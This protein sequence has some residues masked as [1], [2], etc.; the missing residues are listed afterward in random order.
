MTGAR[1]ER[2]DLEGEQQRL[3]LEIVETYKQGTRERGE[4]WFSKTNSGS[5]LQHMGSDRTWHEVPDHDLAALRRSGLLDMRRGGGRYPPLIHT[6]SPFGLR[7][8]DWVRSQDAEPVGQVEEAVRE[9]VDS[10]WFV[11]RYP[12]SHA[13]WSSAVAM[14]WSPDVDRNLSQIGHSCREAM[15]DFAEELAT[16]A[17]ML[18]DVD[19]DKQ[20]TVSR[21]RDVLAEKGPP[22]SRAAFNGAL[23]AYW[24][25]LSDQVMRQEHA[26]QKEG[27][28]IGWEDA[29]RVVLHTLVV[30][31]EVARVAE[32]GQ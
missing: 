8:Y 27:E 10:D 28:P 23:V 22:G 24:G 25:E 5:R 17:C 6:V 14:L 1:F 20:H 4:F 16:R 30:M 12:A 2:V 13:A 29:R 11:G 31:Y 32:A 18:D 19:S 26:G 21:V 15:Q 3:L 9:L 7:Y